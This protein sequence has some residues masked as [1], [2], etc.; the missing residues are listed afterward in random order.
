VNKDNSAS[1]LSG[2]TTLSKLDLSSITT[3]AENEQAVNATAQNVSAAVN[4]IT[5]IL[6]QFKQPQK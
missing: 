4:A 1:I 5:G 3:A 6:N 2:L